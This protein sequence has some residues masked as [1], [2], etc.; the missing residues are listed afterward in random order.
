MYQQALWNSCCAQYTDLDMSAGHKSTCTCKLP[1]FQKY[2]CWP[3]YFHIAMT[4][5]LKLFWPCGT[6]ISPNSS[7]SLINHFYILYWFGRTWKILHTLNISFCRL[8]IFVPLNMDLK[9]WKSL[10]LFF[11]LYPTEVSLGQ[12]SLWRSPHP[13]FSLRFFGRLYFQQLSYFGWQSQS[14][15][16]HFDSMLSAKEK[17]PSILMHPGQH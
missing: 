15:N 9:A 16:L 8:S 4:K 13:Q 6:N 7:L 2:F 5:V 17:L 1:A 11:H 3:F 14:D 12:V 10:I